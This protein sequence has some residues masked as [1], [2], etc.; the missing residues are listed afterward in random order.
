MQLHHIG[1][2]CKDIGL[3][4]AHIH[5]LHQVSTV[6]GPV[7]DAE[8]N[9]TLA[10]VT[11]TDG[12]NLELISGNPVQNLLKRQISYYHICFETDD[13]NNQIN[14]LLAGGAVLV[15]APKPAILFKGRQVAFLQASYGLIELLAIK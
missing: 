5:N 11:L 9:A 7:F 1:I 2:A 12:T 3:E 13:I 10:L 4:L 8:Q 14:Q 6:E 15:S